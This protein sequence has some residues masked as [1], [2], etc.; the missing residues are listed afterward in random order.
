M[1]KEVISGGVVYPLPM[2]KRL[3]GRPSLIVLHD[4]IR[5]QLELRAARLS[6]VCFHNLIQYK[7]CTIHYTV[8]VFC[9]DAMMIM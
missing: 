6:G 5:A 3:P 8:F 9:C 1:K 4:P 7:T 2:G